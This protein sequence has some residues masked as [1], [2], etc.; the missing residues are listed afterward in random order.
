MANS[1]KKTQAEISQLAPI[2]KDLSLSNSS[3]TNLY[4]NHLLQAHQPDTKSLQDTTM[5]PT[6]KIILKENVTMETLALVILE[7]THPNIKV[8][9]F[10]THTR[11]RLLCLKDTSA[12]ITLQNMTAPNTKPFQLQ[13]LQDSRQAVCTEFHYISQDMTL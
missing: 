9:V 8:K 6:Y 4:N 10:K 1:N 7:K 13:R 2:G 12:A 3:N 5:W 11:Q